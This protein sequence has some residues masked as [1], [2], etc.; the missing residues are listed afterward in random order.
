M[1]HYILAGSTPIKHYFDNEFNEIVKSINQG[2]GTIISYTQQENNL[3]L[4]LG[5]LNGWRDFIIISESEVEK[6]KRET[7]LEIEIKIQ[8]SEVENA[9]HILKNNGY[10]TGNLW[11]IHDVQHKF[12]CSDKE[13]LEVLEGVFTNGAIIE[14]INN[15]ISDY[16]RENGLPEYKE[17][18]FSIS[19]FYKDDKTEFKDYLVYAYD[20]APEDEDINDEDIFFYGLSEEQIISAIKSGENTDLDFV[21]TSYE[22][23]TI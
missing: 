12:K 18:I 19:G 8:P 21:I 20:C 10:Y 3:N 5:I 16:A 14:E 23:A 6:I 1:T 11:T 15:T 4:L 22:K 13:A 2:D 7:D 9:K 17:N